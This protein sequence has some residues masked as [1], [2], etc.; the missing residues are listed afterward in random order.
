MVERGASEEEVVSAI[1]T[2][3]RAPAKHGRLAYR[4]NF[5]Y[6]R[7]WGGK[8]YRIKQLMPIIKEEK[9]RIVVITVY[10]FYF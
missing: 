10:T 5:E 1:A 7:T 6:N 9:G 8:H 3:E 4:R 2:G